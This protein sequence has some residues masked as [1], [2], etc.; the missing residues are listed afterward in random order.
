MKNL[1]RVS[2]T[3]QANLGLSRNL[4]RSA[5]LTS[6]PVSLGRKAI[7]VELKDS[8]FKQAKI[9]ISMAAKRFHSEGMTQDSLI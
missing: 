5:L 1:W 7:G 6:S 4:C 8:Y 3:P 9:N 2:A